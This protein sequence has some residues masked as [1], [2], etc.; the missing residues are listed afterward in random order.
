MKKEKLTAGIL[1]VLFVASIIT[2]GIVFKSNLSLKSGLD[3]E[4]LRSESLLSEKLALD[5]EIEK[6]QKEMS[7]LKGK[8]QE[9]DR[10]LASA[11]QQLAEKQKIIASLTK[12]NAT[13]KDLK[14]QLADIQKIKSDLDKQV[15]MLQEANSKLLAEN[16]GLQQSILDLQ[17][18]N[19]A[20]AQDLDLIRNTNAD[21]FQ[22]LTTKGK[23]NEKLT[24]NAARTKKM[25]VNFE[26]PKTYTDDI[27]FRITTPDGKTISAEDKSLTWVFSE[28]SKIMT[29]SLNGGPGD[30]EVT[31][32]VN[33]TYAP[34][35]KMKSGTYRIE[36]LNH[37]EYLGSCRVKLR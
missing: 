28:D 2:S 21:N 8:N 29:A 36:I 32:S 14:K 30:I 6:F 24:I 22:V 26:V 12:E 16:E 35:E 1:T 7:L 11:N 25:S 33:M 13:V 4:K 9:T 20:L 31:R 15:A 10:L 19:A 3:D 18:Q 23:K 37:G 5:K 17:G 34:K 27:S